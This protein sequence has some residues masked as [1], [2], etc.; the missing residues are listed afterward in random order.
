MDYETLR[1]VRSVLFRTF[2]VG[3]VIALLMFL[4]T[5][6]F[7]AACAEWTIAWFRIDPILFAMTMLWYFTSAKFF[8]VYLLL[9]PALGVWWA[10]KAECDRSR[11]LEMEGED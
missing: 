3:A 7:W 2:L 6:F 10:M 5:Q 1:L 8:L 4:F 11:K 9:T